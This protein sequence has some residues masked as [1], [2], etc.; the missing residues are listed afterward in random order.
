MV[1]V[2]S[3]VTVIL[4]PSTVN[5]CVAL[6]ARTLLVLPAVNVTVL[7]E[8]VAAGAKI[9]VAV[10]SDVN[11]VCE[12]VFSKETN[13][14]PLSTTVQFVSGLVPPTPYLSLKALEI[15][16]AV[17]PANNSAVVKA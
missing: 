7:T 15:S 8:F 2:P 9:V 3:P 11:A 10:E 14:L 12:A 17:A 13:P 4:V 5:T 1:F 16:A 6:V